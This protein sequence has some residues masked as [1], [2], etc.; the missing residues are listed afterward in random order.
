MEAWI[1]SIAWALLCSLAQGLLS[2]AALSLLFKLQPSMP[3]R[4]RYN[5]SLATMSVLLIWFVATWW[6]SFAALQS[7]IGAGHFTILYPEQMLPGYTKAY[8]GMPDAVRSIYPWLALAYLLG[9]S[10][11]L[12]R[13]LTGMQQLLSLRRKGHIKA[14]GVPDD[15]VDTLRQKLGIR[16]KVQLLLSLRAQVPMVI[17][18]LKPVILLPAAA[19]ARLSIEQLET[20]LLH[21]LAHIKR[22][23]YL[24]NIL[25]TAA[26]TLLFFNPFVW[27]I[28][29]VVRREREH[30]CDDIV[31]Q[32]SSTPIVYAQALAA[33]ASNR[34]PAFAIAASG[35]K[36]QLFNRIKRIMEMK[37]NPFSYS[38]TAAAVLIIAGI[39]LA[40]AWVS[41]TL[42]HPGDS[43]PGTAKE[44]AAQNGADEETRLVQQLMKDGMVD[45]VKGF[46]VEKI[47]DKLFINGK[48]Q[49]SKVAAKYLDG[50]LS[51]ELRVQVF[52]LSERFRM[53]PDAGLMQNLMPAS[54]SSPCVQKSSKPGC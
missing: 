16:T 18:F 5:L 2:Y 48:E 46:T 45:E 28:S 32:H 15:L 21:E 38:R 33:V 11:M 36:H 7:T 23:D 54:F 31:L 17:G 42:A 53:H 4:L 40:T 51:D 44:A 37:K 9:L 26:E 3:A 13:L 41:P 6:R 30:C 10:F 12:L 49:S 35:N 1:Q 19:I 29:A 39:S 24:V 34:G 52:S 14:D 47:Q 25:Q 8:K 20:I 50:L 43:K 27:M 22:Q